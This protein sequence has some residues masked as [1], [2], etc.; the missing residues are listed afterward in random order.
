MHEKNIMHR[1]LKPENLVFRKANDTTS[2]I[3]ADFGLATDINEANFI[4]S[5]C[6]TPGYVA[7]EVINLRSLSAKY[8]YACDLFSAGCIFYLLLTKIP[9]F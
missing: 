7:P 1:D 6:G 9:L 4:F 5:R 3:I 8:G 2:I